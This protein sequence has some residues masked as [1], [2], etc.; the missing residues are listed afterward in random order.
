MAWNIRSLDDASAAVR[1]AFRRYLPGTD[2]ALKNNFVTIVA[3]VLAALSYEFELRMGWLSKQ[4]LLS[5]STNL[6]WI[7][8][9]A[10]EVGIYQRTAVAASGE[11][12]GAGAATTTYPSGIRFI[13]GNVTY[14][15]TAAVTS[16]ADGSMTVPVT[17]EV[18]GSVGNR[19]SAG[20]LSLADPGL[21]TTLGA[22]WTVDDDGLGGGADAEDADSLKERALQRKRNPPGGGTLTDYERIAMSVSGVL[23]AWA[24]RVPNSPGGV[25]VHFLFGGR[26]DNIPIASDVEAVQAAIDAQRLI[27][28]DDSVATAPVPRPVDVTITGLSGDT[29]E[30]RGAIES[31]IAAM[32]IVRCRPGLDGDTFTISRS[33]YSEVISGVTGE[34][35]HTLV[36]PAADIVLTGGQFPVNGEFDYGS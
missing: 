22:N 33:W 9:H 24:F 26:D 23:K 31:G 34:D 11:I 25:V 27:R 5:T 36:E 28:V 16:G 14:V 29:T 17:A 18:K 15:S 21:Y 30:I 20:L 19:D 32:Y 6:A 4:I 10:A 1:G 2:T 8:L 12:T 7:K 3:K 35:R 13:S